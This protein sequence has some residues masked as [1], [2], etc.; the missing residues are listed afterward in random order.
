MATGKTNQFPNVNLFHSS[1]C[2]QVSTLVA[3]C[4][5]LTD[6]LTGGCWEVTSSHT[7]EC[8]LCTGNQMQKKM[9][10]IW[11]NRWITKNPHR[12]GCQATDADNCLRLGPRLSPAPAKTLVLYLPL[13]LSVPPLIWSC[14]CHRGVSSPHYVWHLRRSA[15]C[16]T[17]M[18]YSLRTPACF[19]LSREWYGTS[20]RD[21]S[22]TGDPIQSLIG[23]PDA[24]G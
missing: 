11:S 14:L 3:T 24:G 12:T 2:N 22:F 8:L 15:R 6:W 7:L 10:Q 1:T 23:A 20:R 16:E 13:R 18:K 4:V 19:H 9:W 5:L 17:E 21:W